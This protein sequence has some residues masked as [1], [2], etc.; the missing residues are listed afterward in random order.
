MKFLAVLMIGLAALFTGA[1]SGTSNAELTLVAQNVALGT[2]IA[3]VRNT[4]TVEADRLQVTAVYIETAIALSLQQNQRLS[5]T[6][7]ALGGNPALVAP[8][9]G[10]PT[11]L[12]ALDA[13]VPA[14]TSEAGVSAADG[15]VVAATATPAS[16]SLYNAVT[17]RGVGANDCALA[18]VTDFGAADTN[19]Y[20]VAT[21]SNIAPGMVLSSRWYLEGQEVIAH[22]FTPDF[23]IDQNCIWFYID[24]T[25][26]EFT[27]GNWTVQLEINGQLAAEPV[28]FT[29]SG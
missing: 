21:A 18:S 7:E 22:E 23:A 24:S 5:A 9:A 4:A 26:T 14:T 19:I 15:T 2:Q 6:I 3:D 27:P 17:A 10:T 1:C 28:A 16:P 25:E 12:P 13:A 11:P 8:V 20:I 29:I